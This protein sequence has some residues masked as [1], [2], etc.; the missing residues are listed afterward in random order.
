MKAFD[1]LLLILITF[2]NCRL[3]SAFKVRDAMQEEKIMQFGFKRALPFRYEK[4]LIVVE[5][6]IDNEPYNFIFDTGASTIID[7]DF[8]KKVK[9]KKIG[10]QK[11]KDTR[12]KNKKLKVIKINKVSI[13]GIDFSDIVTSISDLDNLKNTT[14]I[15][16]VGILG[17]NVMNKCVW[18]I[19]YQKKII[20][21]TDSRDSLMQS[22]SRKTFDFYAE[23]KKTPKIR[24]SIDGKYIDEVLL[25][26]GSNGGVDLPEKHL[27]DIGITNKFIIRNSMI[28]GLLSESI[29]T[30]KTTIIPKLTLGRGT[31][32]ENSFLTFNKIS[33]SAL[34]GNRF[35][36]D[37][38]VTIDWKYQEI[39]L[40]STQKNKSSIN[41]TFGFSCRLKEQ[42]LVIGSLTENSSA[43]KAGLKINDEILQI[44]EKNY[45]NF[46]YS[47]YCELLEN[48]IEEKTNELLIT[49]KRGDKEMQVKV[50][51]TDLVNEV[52]NY[53]Y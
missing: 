40:V 35:L 17:A 48:E 43:D 12:G 27:Q 15:D 32:I 20:I 46:N 42:I 2:S 30:S 22:S 44:D 26:T 19:D 13:G 7:D 21:L 23:G 38:L 37:Y 29:E 34:I 39:T 5:A 18:Q 41:S 3:I 8:A 11:H 52:L 47:D 36:Q 1:L 53:R 9:Y 14:C 10:I 16:F 6:R 51:K 24:L 33:P 25:D 4:G 50:Y 31:E 45:R 49:V 28:S